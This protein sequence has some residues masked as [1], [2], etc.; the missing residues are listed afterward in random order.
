MTSLIGLAG[1]SFLSTGGVG[2]Y[3]YYYPQQR[4]LI[5]FSFSICERR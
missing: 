1:M 2:L 3:L 5:D 4:S